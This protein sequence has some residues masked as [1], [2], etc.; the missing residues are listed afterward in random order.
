MRFA[1]GGLFKMAT[2]RSHDED[3]PINI[4]LRSNG[5]AVLRGKQHLLAFDPKARQISWSVEYAAPGVPGWENVVMLAIT[6]ASYGM[7]MSGAASTPFGSPQNDM[8]NDMHRDVAIAYNAFAFRRFSASKAGTK[9]AYVL[10][11]LG[12]GKERGAGII[13]VDLDS[14]APATQLMFKD[15]EPDYQVDDVTG[16]LYNIK[17]KELFA[18]A[19]K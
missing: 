13:A 12:E 1:R 16:R 10:T 18:Y 5:T 8:F 15:R 7:A 9:Y 19:L 3:P 11:M 6:A 4:S 17:G 14:G 2:E